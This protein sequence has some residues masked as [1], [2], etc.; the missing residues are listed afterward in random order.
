MVIVTR[1]SHLHTCVRSLDLRLW[2][3]S[4]DVGDDPL[5]SVEREGSKMPLTMAQLMVMM[6]LDRSH[7]A[8]HPK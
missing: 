2:G 6:T 8:E 4:L 3:L 1:H 7:F 5:R